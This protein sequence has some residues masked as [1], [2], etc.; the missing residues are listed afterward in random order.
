VGVLR[1]TRACRYGLRCQQLWRDSRPRAAN[2]P[3]EFSSYPTRFP[4]PV[5][6]NA[7]DGM[8]IHGQL[9]SPPIPPIVCI[10]PHRVRT[11]RSPTRDAA[12]LALHGLLFKL[13]CPEPISVSRGYIVL[14]I[15]YA[16][17]SAT[18]S[19]SARLWNYGP[20]GA[21]EFLDVEA[22]AAIYAAAA[23]LN[24][25]TSAFGRSWGG[26]LTGLALARASGLFAAGVDMSGCMTLTSIIQKT[27]PFP[28]PI[29]SPMPDGVSRGNPLP[30]RPSGHGIPPCF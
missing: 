5:I 12:G 1:S 16:E 9:F 22:A 6:F 13:L 2:H 7:T 10:I 28:T 11:R 4:Q 19:I 8:Q 15:N 3:R 26:Y 21:S 24:R 29:P 14:S 20:T 17:A 18:D 27:L 30:F 23:M 25:L